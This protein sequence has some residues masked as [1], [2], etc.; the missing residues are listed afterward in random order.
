[1]APFDQFQNWFRPH[2]LRKHESGNCRK[3]DKLGSY[4]FLAALLGLF[5]THV[6]LAGDAAIAIGLVFRRP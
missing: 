1:M 3:D 5:G 4:A 6:F 2:Y